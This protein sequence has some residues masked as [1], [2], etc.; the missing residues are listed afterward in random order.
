[1]R[2]L[3]APPVPLPFPN[4]PVKDRCFN[5]AEPVADIRLVLLF[6]EV[7]RPSLMSPA[8]DMLGRFC[9]SVFWS[10][11]NFLLLDIA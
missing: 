1:V 3:L 6:C 7:E 11:T 10:T 5:E 2:I 8:K 4:I 9:M